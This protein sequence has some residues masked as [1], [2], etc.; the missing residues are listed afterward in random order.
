MATARAT[1]QPG[2]H[3]TGGGSADKTNRGFPHLKQPQAAQV[4]LGH[5]QLTCPSL[6]PPHVVCCH[7]PSL[8]SAFFSPLFRFPTSLLW[9][10]RVRAYC[11]CHHRTKRTVELTN[12]LLE[13]FSYGHPSHLVFLSPAQGN[14]LREQAWKENRV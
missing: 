8:P 3:H 10:G 14:R 2:W 9:R 1:P 12:L 5:L 13:L 6:C 7:F 11:P 4:A